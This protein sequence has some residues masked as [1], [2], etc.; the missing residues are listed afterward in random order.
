MEN[1]QLDKV[2]GNKSLGAL[3]QTPKFI[4]LSCPIETGKEKRPCSNPAKPASTDVGL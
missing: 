2:Y 3:P 1:Q 4:A